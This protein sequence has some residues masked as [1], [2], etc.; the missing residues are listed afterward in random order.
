MKKRSLTIVIVSYN[1]SFWLKKTL[2]SLQ[3]YY[4]SATATKVRVMLVDN[5]SSEDVVEMVKADFSW[6]EVISLPENRGFA[7]ANNVALKL[8]KSDYVMLLNPD[9]QLDERSQLDR[10]LDRL[11]DEPQIGMIGPCLLLTDGRMDMACHRGEPTLWASLCYFL[12]LEKL[13]P[14]WRLVNGYHRQ[15]FDLKTSH[16]VDAISGAA[17]MIR[18]ETMAEV[19]FLDE[20]FFLYAED[21]DWC[22]RFRDAGYQIWYEPAVTI[23]HH[24]NKTGIA[25]QDA[26]ISGASRQHFFNTMLQY[27]DKH[28]AQQYPKWMRQLL[29]VFLFVKREGI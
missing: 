22:K 11:Q 26:K 25:N 5:H 13:F 6:V 3:E 8:V 24:K 10:L 23:I 18:T 19:G 12:K 14:R 27:Y 9:T 16:Q 1:G 2:Q 4:L 17:M 28:Y 15:D 29:R 20:R 7:G 21:L